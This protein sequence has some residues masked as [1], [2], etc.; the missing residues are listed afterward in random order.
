MC[1]MD[2]YGFVRT[3]SKEAKFVKCFQTGDIVR[4]CVMNG[5]KVGTYVGRVAV[6]TNGSSNIITAYST[7]QGISFKYCQAVHRMD[8]YSY[9]VG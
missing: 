1:H 2:K 3:G 4:A 6:H 9:Q 8:G 7:I 5:K